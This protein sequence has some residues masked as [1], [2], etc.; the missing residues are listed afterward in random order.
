M[1]RPE[2]LNNDQ[3]IFIAEL[4]QN[5]PAITTRDVISAVKN[6]LINKMK[7]ASPHFTAQELERIVVDEQLS[8]T[9]IIKYLTEVRIN[10]SLI[11]D[12]PWNTAA[13]NAEPITTEALPWLISIQENRILWLSKMLTEREAKWFNRLFGFKSLFSSAVLMDMGIESPDSSL[14]NTY[15]SAM[16]ATWAQIYANREKVAEV[17]G[18]E[19]PDFSDLDSCLARYNSGD[20]AQSVARQ[21]WDDID[22]I[23]EK[24][25][26]GVITG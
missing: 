10:L 19:K 18:I 6:Y 7:E 3:K 4:K 2:K 12:T 5:N 13:L 20:L 23:F 17:A 24:I 1:A 21:F 26:A 15:Q 8:K 9:A 14:V 22:V 25:E 11:I 16:V